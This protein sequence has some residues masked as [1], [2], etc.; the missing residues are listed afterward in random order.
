M[1]H[2]EC[3]CGK[4]MWDGDGHIVYDVF[5]KNDLIEYIQNGK[6]NNK[7]KDIY[8]NYSTFY[9]D[10]AYFWL[11]DECKTVH[12]W[13]STPKYCART[14][15]LRKKIQKI[16]IENIKKLNEYFV[17]GIN[18]DELI[19][20]VPIKKFIEKNTIRPYKYYVTNDLTKVYII[21]TDTNELDRVYDLIY[22]SFTEYDFETD[23]FDNLLIYTIYKK[24]KD[25]EYVVENGVRKQKDAD[26]YPHKQV[27]FVIKE[28]DSNGG[29]ISY[30]DHKLKPEIYTINNMDEFN[31]KYGKYYSKKE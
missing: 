15:K 1:A 8:D 5:N 16:S 10:N 13:S 19:D 26:D 22:E 4:D 27:N 21:N 25:H 28:N 12:L 31:K 29:S 6:M 30:V 2:M 23:V 9:E 20:D 14:Y 7:F 3:I 18:E 11:C 17:I 24:N